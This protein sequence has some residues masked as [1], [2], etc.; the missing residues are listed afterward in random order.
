MGETSAVVVR[1]LSL[2]KPLV[3]SD[4][5]A[6]SELPDDVALKVPVDGREAD[7]LDAAL[8]AVADPAQR[9][10]M[11][12]AARE[13]AE[14]EHRLDRVADAYAAALH[15]AVATEAATRRYVEAT[16]AKLAQEP[17]R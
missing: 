4:V 5:G 15:E 1:A 16:T 13:L 8:E 3:V 14:R 9:A 11:G 17:P 2:G 7:A 12:A 10:A 6:F